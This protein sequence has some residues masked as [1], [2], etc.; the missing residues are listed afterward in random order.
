[1]IKVDKKENENQ[2]ALLE[3]GV[4]EIPAGY[5]EPALEQMKAAAVK[6]F[7]ADGLKYEGLDVFATPR[8]LILFVKNL[9]DKSQTRYEEIL[10]PSLKSAKDEKGNFTRAAMGFA[11]KYG[12]FPQ[13][14]K[15]KSTNRGDYF[16]FA[17]EIK[18]QKAQKLLI[19]IFP[20]IIKSIS[21]P[22][23]MVWEESGFRFARPIRSI[24]ALYGKK[25]IRFAIADVSAS[26]WTLGLRALGNVKVPIKIPSEYVEKLKNKSVI[27]K[28]QERKEIARKSINSAVANVGHIIADEDLLDEINYL[29]EYPTAVL[30]E[31]DKKFLA[32]PKE[33]LAMCLRKNQKCFSVSGKNGAFTNYFVGVRNG[34]SQYQDIVRKGYEKVA[35]A[36]LS[37]AEFFYQNDLK[38]G[39]EPNVEKLKNIVFHKDI[40]TIHEKVLR[41]EKISNL[42]AEQMGNVDKEDLKKAVYLSKADLVSEMVF[43]YPQLQGTMGRIYA[44]KLGQKEAIAK[45]IEEHYLP[46]SASGTLP[47]GAL[48]LIIA[49]ADRLD[50]LVANFSVGFEPTG[51]ADPYGLR[52]AGI[53]VVRI[54]QDKFP[55]W[56]IE[57]L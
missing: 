7:A 54:A 22:K 18:G 26:N 6:L 55:T 20:D 49:F 44:S 12:L 30:C 8:K 50:S 39:L 38:K 56:D 46:L 17:Q 3:I 13:D 42:I 1:M 21:F 19:S 48:G 28:Q 27:V 25:I 9:S 43:E 41:I 2:D 47:A 57:P 15:S 31:F 33:V 10:G 11:S 23:N 52:R 53:I 36:R 29:V 5:I 24:L 35:G 16:F 37:D 32:L 45:A 51:S 34:L 4:E 40:G 14:L